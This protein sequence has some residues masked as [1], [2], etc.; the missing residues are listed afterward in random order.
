[1]LAV[2]M[3]LTTS[4]T[5]LAELQNFNSPVIDEEPIAI[6]QGADIQNPATRSS[7]ISGLDELTQ[8]KVLESARASNVDLSI[9]TIFLYEDGLIVFL[10]PLDP[11]EPYDDVLLDEAQEHKSFNAPTPPLLQLK[12][13][14]GIRY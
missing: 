2:A 14:L 4:F 8:N 3:T 13:F 9:S 5:V 7:A 10:T 6:I 12:E 11:I 1:M